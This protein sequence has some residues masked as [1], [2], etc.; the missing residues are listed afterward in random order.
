ME[1][2][3]YLFVFILGFLFGVGTLWVICKKLITSAEERG[4]VSAEAETIRL[5]TLLDGQKQSSDEKIQLL[6]DAKKSLS[7]EFAAISNDVL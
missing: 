1:I 4:R 5:K 6:L 3:S 2:Y 7:Q